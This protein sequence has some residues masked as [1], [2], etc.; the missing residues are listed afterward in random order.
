MTNE[1]KK[2]YLERG[3]VICPNCGSDNISGGD[4]PMDFVGGSIFQKIR[5]YECG[6]EWE[7]QYDLVDIELVSP[8][9]SAKKLYLVVIEGDVEPRILAEYATD[10]KRVEAARKYRQEHG[11]ED[12]LFR[13]DIDEN[14]V[15]ELDSFGAAEI[16]I[17]ED[18]EC[19]L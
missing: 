8:E 13:M 15:P 11:D 16:D 14:G 1:Q 6:T 10:E 17:W 19:E 4:S 2:M 9:K 7:D 5:C 12:G 18:E 3:G